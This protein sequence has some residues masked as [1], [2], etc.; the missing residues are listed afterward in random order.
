MKKHI[1][2]ALENEKEY[3]KANGK[4]YCSLTKIP[5]LENEIIGKYDN[6]E[7]LLDCML[8][9]GYVGLYAPSM[10]TRVRGQLYIDGSLSNNSP[11]PYPHLPS[12]VLQIWHWRWINPLWVHVS[13]SE[14]WTETMFTWGKEDAEKNLSDLAFIL[15]YKE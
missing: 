9:S 10:T 15:T 12:K 1:L 14:E 13:S 5:Y 2:M 8:A 11:V 3:E 7:D 4:F 6:N